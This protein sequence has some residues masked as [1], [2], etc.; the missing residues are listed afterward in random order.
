MVYC[1]M[2]M[3]KTSR[4]IREAREEAG[5]HYPLDEPRRHV[6]ERSDRM[7]AALKERAQ[8]TVIGARLAEGKERIQQRLKAHIHPDG[9]VAHAKGASKE[10]VGFY[11][12]TAKELQDCTQYRP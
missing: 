3:S 12:T 5:V 7:K 4:K 8:E 9:V 1:I 2:L 10:L 11:V 6:A